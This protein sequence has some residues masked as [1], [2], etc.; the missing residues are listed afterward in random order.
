MD[1]MNPNVAKVSCFFH[2]FCSIFSLKK[3]FVLE[4]IFA[5]NNN[6]IRIWETVCCYFFHF[7]G[8]PFFSSPSNIKY[9]LGESFS[10]FLHPKN[11]VERR[12]RRRIFHNI[13]TKMRAQT[14]KTFPF[15]SLQKFS[16]CL[17]SKSIFS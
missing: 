11:E 6:R 7:F 8:S 10:F 14:H 16:P 17:W 1:M 2:P 3:M 15:L 13:F 9:L 12:K 5:W 4:K